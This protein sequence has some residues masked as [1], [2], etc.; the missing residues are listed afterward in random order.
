MLDQEFNQKILPKLPGIEFD[1][2]NKISKTHSKKMDIFI[3]Q[4][5]YHNLSK[6]IETRI[7]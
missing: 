3:L 6:A 4:S 5:Q 2:K 7:L 1:E